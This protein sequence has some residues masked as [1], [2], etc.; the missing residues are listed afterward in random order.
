L[1]IHGLILV[2]YVHHVFSNPSIQPFLV[3]KIEN[4]GI[5]GKRR[6]CSFI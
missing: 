3:S 5:V 6:L 1:K 4:F 2:Q